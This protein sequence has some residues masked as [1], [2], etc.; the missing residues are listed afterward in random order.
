MSDLEPSPRKHL[1]LLVTAPGADGGALVRYLLAVG[2]VSVSATTGCHAQAL[3]E[4]V[5]FDILIVDSGLLDADLQLR[6][7]VDSTEMP[8]V[9]VGH[10]E[11]GVPSGAALLPARTEPF[12][13]ALGVQRLTRDLERGVLSWGPFSLDTRRRECSWLDRPV[14]LTPTQFRIMAALVHARGSV[15]SRQELCRR[16]LGGFVAGDGE[17]LEAHLRRIRRLLHEG[18]GEPSFIVT[19]RGE[20]VRL[21]DAVAAAPHPVAT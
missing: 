19:V 15:V 14:R 6:Q 8:V 17:R 18:P 9:V 3:V 4:C 10:P 1:A 20:G 5:A 2:A 21:A 11:T 12:E 13:V 7:L 16:S